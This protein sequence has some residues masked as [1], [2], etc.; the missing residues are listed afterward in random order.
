MKSRFLLLWPALLVAFNFLFWNEAPGL[1]MLLFAMLV[2]TALFLR[3]PCAWR[4]RK[5]Q[6]SGICTLACGIAVTL[7][8]PGWGVFALIFSLSV[9]AVFVMEPLFRSVSG[10][11]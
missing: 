6:V 11:A 10:A 3:S 8:G 7:Y 5:V 2:M 1:N 9:F 4:I